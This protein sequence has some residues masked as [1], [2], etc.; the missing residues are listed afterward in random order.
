LGEEWIQAE[1]GTV[2]LIRTIERLELKVSASK[3]EVVAFMSENEHVPGLMPL[4]LEGRRGSV[5]HHILRLTL[6]L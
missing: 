4:R 3:T 1:L 5:V 6:D 2:C